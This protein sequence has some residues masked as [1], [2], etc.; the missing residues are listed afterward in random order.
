MVRENLG[1]N[2]SVAPQPV[3]N[4]TITPDHFHMTDSLYLTLSNNPELAK[5]IV[6]LDSTVNTFPVDHYF[7]LL[8]HLIADLHKQSAEPKRLS[9]SCFLHHQ[10][11]LA[12]RSA[13]EQDVLLSVCLSGCSF[14]VNTKW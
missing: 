9:I 7:L 6:Y 10:Q 14:Y 13:T 3:G 12:L 5:I 8:P 4:L 11:L 1:P 2:K